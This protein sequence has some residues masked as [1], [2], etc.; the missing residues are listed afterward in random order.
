MKKRKKGIILFLLLGL[1]NF[2]IAQS[3]LDNTKSSSTNFYLNHRKGVSNLSLRMGG[4][5]YSNFGYYTFEY[6]KFITNKISIGVGPV[7][8]FG[9]IENNIKYFDG[10][11]NAV[12]SY[13]IYDLKDKLFL[14]GIVNVRAGLQNSTNRVYNESKTSF[15]YGGS[16]GF[17]V[18]YFIGK[19]GITAQIQEIF[20]LNS[21]LGFWHYT[22]NVGLKYV[23]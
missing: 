18:E 17:E 22:G 10:T 9:L 8:D 3:S 11:L 20:T 5:K 14:N 1:C 19:I 6:N 7:L 13:T 16:F 2:G 15:I 4:T 21:P 12:G 23:L